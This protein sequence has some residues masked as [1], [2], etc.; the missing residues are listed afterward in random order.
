MAESVSFDDFCSEWL[1]DVCAGNPSTVELGRR[2]ARKL[3][4]QWLDIDDS[5]DDLVYCDGAGDG[6]IDVAYLYRGDDR[7]ADEDGTVQGHTWYLVQSKYGSAF[8][9]T[10]TIVEESLKVIDTLDGRRQRLSSLA[11]G[12]L[13]RLLTFRRQASEADRIVLVFA[14]EQPLTEVEKQRLV[15]VRAVGRDRV[16]RS[17]T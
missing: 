9:G 1:A 16:D 4:T 3:L 14:T 13:D 11:E 5:S 2:F 8:R 17:L 6:G 15:D 10:G 12:L 7:D